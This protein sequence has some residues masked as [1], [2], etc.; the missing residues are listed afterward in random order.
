MPEQD[1]RSASDQS[2][3]KNWLVAI[4]LLLIVAVAAWLLT[5]YTNVPFLAAWLVIA[6]IGWILYRIGHAHILGI[7]LW[8]VA[9]T[10]LSAWFWIPDMSSIMARVLFWSLPLLLFLSAVIVFMVFSLTRRRH[11]I[12]N[13]A[14]CVIA[15]F[16]VVNMAMVYGTIQ[17]QRRGVESVQETRQLVLELHRLSAEIEAIRA[18]LGRLPKD[19]AE[20][21]ALRK[22]PMPEYH[23]GFRISYDRPGS[24][25][26]RRRGDYHLQCGASHFWGTHWDLFP[27]IFHFYG[28]DAEQRLYIESF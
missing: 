17:H 14:G 26:Y 9:A 6:V 24:D 28:P 7:I 15:V 25:D 11:Y 10:L 21:V 1:I 3:A 8:V 5:A 23:P 19:E 4:A 18:R 12:G 16:S 20:L 27:W 13:C 22:K 2:A